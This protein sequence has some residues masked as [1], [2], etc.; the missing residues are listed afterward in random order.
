MSEPITSSVRASWWKASC[1]PS[2]AC[3]SSL[4]VICS[5]PCALL[6]VGNSG[7]VL[8][9]LTVI[10][11]PWLPDTNT[12]SKVRIPAKKSIGPTNFVQERQTRK[13]TTNPFRNFQI[14]SECVPGC[15]AGKDNRAPLAPNAIHSDYHR[16]AIR[17]LSNSTRDT[18]AHP[19]IAR[20]IQHPCSRSGIRRS[21][22]RWN[23]HI[24]GDRAA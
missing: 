15:D 22:T 1:Q 3:P 12:C 18:P 2:S 9:Q 16:D 14:A 6:L 13:W 24:A 11:Y 23:H 10:E 4:R 8:M 20:G 21:A 7:T 5:N 19:C 17:P